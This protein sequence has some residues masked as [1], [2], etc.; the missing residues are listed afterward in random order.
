[1]LS[2]LKP[3]SLDVVGK[4]SKLRDYSFLV[5]SKTAHVPRAA[6]NRRR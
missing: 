1:L 3:A 2:G 5:I 4:T 6:S